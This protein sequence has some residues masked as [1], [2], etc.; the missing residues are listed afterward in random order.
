M[1][2][3]IIIGIAGGT[4]SGK[5]TLAKRLFAQFGND[6]VMLSHDFY[7]KNRLDLPLSER[8]KLNYDHPDAFETQLTI[9][10]LLELKAG[11][12]II[13]PTYD[14][15]NHKRNDAWQPMDAKRIII[16]E[17][18][19]I[20]ENKELCDLM[21]LRLFVDTDADIRFI[22]RLVRD[23]RDRGRSMDAV[24]KQYTSTVKPMH[25][26]FVEPSK[27]RADIIIPE[28]GKNEIAVQMVIDAITNKLQTL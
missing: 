9:K 27:R 11:H 17:G 8:A 23:V 12:S 24:I 21:D 25:D 14:Y 5:T 28:G 10:H 6:A 22:R 1:S 19:L 15:C 4:A 20:F 16:L 26:Q 13:H 3:R 18:I 2:N 7:Y